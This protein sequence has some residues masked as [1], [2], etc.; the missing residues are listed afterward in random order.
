MVEEEAGR[1][2]GVSADRVTINDRVLLLVD[3]PYY[4]EQAFAFPVLSCI[5]SSAVAFKPVA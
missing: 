2:G 1:T 4:R 3:L 5:M